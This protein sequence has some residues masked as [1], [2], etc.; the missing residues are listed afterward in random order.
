MHAKPNRDI[1][2]MV[3][4]KEGL[5]ELRETGSYGTHR[6][7]LVIKHYLLDI[8][9]ETKMASSITRPAKR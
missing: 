6:T 8:C 5:Q 7:F 3:G 4:R 1:M 2:D 9:P